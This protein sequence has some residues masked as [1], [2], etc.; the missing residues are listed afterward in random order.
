M[1]SGVVG[2]TLP[3]CELS[4]GQWLCEPRRNLPCSGQWKEVVSI[5]VYQASLRLPLSAQEELEKPWHP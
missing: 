3:N 4:S 1:L 2:V 5:H